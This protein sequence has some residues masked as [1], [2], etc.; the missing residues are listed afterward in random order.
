MSALLIVAPAFARSQEVPAPPATPE[1]APPPVWTGNGQV[2]FLRTGGNTDTSV[3]G[4]ASE[5]DY[6]GSVWSGA[7][8]AALNRG[9][10]AGEE[11]L[12][13]LAASLR[14][15]RA[16]GP[17]TDF[18]VEAAY[19][20]DTYAGI[21]SRVESQL[22][23]ARK[24][25]EAERHLVSVEGGL[26][27]AH[28]VRLPLREG[29]DFGFGRGRLTYKYKISPTAE[30]QNEASYLANLKQSSDWRFNN[31]AALTA[32]LTSR[33]SLKL[34]HSASH[35]NT[36]PEGKKKTDTIVAAALVAK[37]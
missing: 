8:K 13:N 23:I 29:R 6:K 2:S 15:G 10:V 31:V 28:E 7:A 22:G 17:Q 37:F 1:A 19:A 24:L 9:S 36:P 32:T 34:S 20:E 35:F 27:F 33:F 30:F 3:F 25:V 4:L 26:G 11:N 21:D 5:F 12:R 18:F 14:L 16:L